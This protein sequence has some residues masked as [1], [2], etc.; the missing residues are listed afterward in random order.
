MS[1]YKLNIKWGKEQFTDVELNLGESPLVFKA[2]LFALS[3]VPPERQKILIKGQTVGDNDWSNVA[4][5]L[6]NGITLMMMG[7]AD[8]LLEAPRQQTKFLED[9]NDSQ[10]A[11]ALDLPVGLKNLGNTCYLN[12]VA[13]CLKS[14]P[15]LCQGLTKYK[16]SDGDMAGSLVLS[17]RDTYNFMEKYKQSDY[18]PLLLVQLGKHKISFLF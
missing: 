1:V 11:M 5:N 15:E 12:A 8:K 16:N 14:V 3:G 18:P 2:Q 6:K 7:S 10:L 13:Q 4:N 9:L 17:L